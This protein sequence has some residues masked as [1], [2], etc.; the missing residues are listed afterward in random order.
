M[1]FEIVKS[2]SI[3]S[4]GITWEEG[5]ILIDFFKWQLWIETDKL[6]NW[7]KENMD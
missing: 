5:A 3:I 4:F 7:F 1:K 2:E 6:Y